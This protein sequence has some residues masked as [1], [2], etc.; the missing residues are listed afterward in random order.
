MRFFCDSRIRVW[1]LFHGPFDP[2]IISHILCGTLRSLNDAISNY[3]TWIIDIYVL[4]VG[5]NVVQILSLNSR[6]S[7][8]A[9]TL[10]ELLIILFTICR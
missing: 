1:C 7:N 5:L 6:Y 4:D 3:V 2:D 9:A 8:H 10:L